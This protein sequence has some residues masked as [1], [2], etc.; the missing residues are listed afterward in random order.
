MH[1]QQTVPG[2][3]MDHMGARRR[4]APKCTLTS[5]Y[6]QG[7]YQEPDT[8]IQLNTRAGAVDSRLSRG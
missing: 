6:L 2:R 4:W 8:I 1:V 3:A 5:A 7:A